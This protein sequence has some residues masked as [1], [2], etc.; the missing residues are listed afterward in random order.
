MI[1]SSKDNARVKKFT[2]LSQSRSERNADGLFVL[3]GIRLVADAIAENAPFEYILA[4]QKALASM[5][6][7]IPGGVE[8]LCITDEIASKISATRSPQGIFAVCRVLDKIN[9]RGT[10][11]K[12]GKYVLLCGIQDPGNLGMILRTADA[13]GM[14]G[15]FLSGCC[16]IYNP[17]VVRATMGS[18]FRVAFARAEDSEIM[19]L[20]AEAGI[21]TFAAVVDGGCDAAQTKFPPGSALLIGNE[22]SGL[23]EILSAA[24]DSRITI[25]MSGSIESL[26][27]AMAAGI[28]MYLMTSRQ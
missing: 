9:L 27:A 24:C 4:T 26:N 11:Y 5:E 23:P 25:R 2:K 12:K 6:L 16:D 21:K 10:I 22:G 18:L 13:M 20:F 14:D 17:K 8:T 19:A 7:K 15:V 1:I 3:E 28:L